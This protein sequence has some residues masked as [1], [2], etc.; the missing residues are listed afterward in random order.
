MAETDTEVRRVVPV[1]EDPPPVVDTSGTLAVLGHRAIGA[2]TSAGLAVAVMRAQAVKAGD[3]DAVVA[4]NEIFTLLD[5]AAT[6]ARDRI[7]LGQARTVGRRR[8]G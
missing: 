3:T 5:R 8:A 7:V 6:T 4:C 1:F 2:L